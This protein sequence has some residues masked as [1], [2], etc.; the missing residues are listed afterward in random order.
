MDRASLLTKDEFKECVFALAQDIPVEILSE[1]KRNLLEDQI[2]QNLANR[3]NCK[4]EV[5]CPCGRVDLLSDEML[6]EVKTA[7]LWKSA[8]GQVLSY[9]SHFPG[10]QQVI[11]LFDVPESF[12]IDAVSD[13]CRNLGII[14]MTEG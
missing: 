12:D 1:P 13:T 9:A 4:R 7:R 8:V 3:F 10:R 11:Y 6:I 14:V 2:Q 5:R